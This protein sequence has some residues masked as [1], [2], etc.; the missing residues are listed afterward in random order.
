ESIDVAHVGGVVAHVDL[1][2]EAPEALE[3]GRGLEVAA[4]DAVAHPA[5]HVGDGAHAGAARTHHVDAPRN[6]EVEH[7]VRYLCRVWSFAPASIVQDVS[8]KGRD[9]LT[10][11]PAEH[12]ANGPSVVIA[13]GGTGGHIFP[14]LALAGALRRQEPAALV[15]FLG[16]ARGL[17]GTLIPEAGYRLHLVDMVPFSGGRRLVAPAP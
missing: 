8:S 11:R 10:A 6:R 12:D 9:P 17:E 3:A 15:S 13:A 16:T 4:R 5:E 1:D 2:A 14:G 7:E